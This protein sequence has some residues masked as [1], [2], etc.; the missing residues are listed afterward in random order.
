MTLP[1]S[2]LDVRK[3]GPWAIAPSCAGLAVVAALCSGAVGIAGPVHAETLSAQSRIEGV[4]VFPRGAEVVRVAKIRIPAGQHVVA[5]RDLPAQ[6]VG[7]SI[8]V[9]GKATGALQI[10][11]VD[12]RRTFITRA[13]EEQASLRRRIEADIERLKDER[14]LLEAAVETAETQAELIRNLVQLP[15]APAGGQAPSS[16]VAPRADWGEIY[17]LIGSRLNEARQKALESRVKLRDLDRRIEDLSKQLTAAAPKKTERTEVMV[18]VAAAGPLDAEL[19]VRYQVTDASWQPRYDARLETGARNVAPK[20]TLVRRAAIRQRTGESWEEV[21]LQL[22]T[23]RPA[24][25]TTTPVLNPVT[26]DIQLDLPRPAPVASAPPQVGAVRT[27][28]AP[29]AEAAKVADAEPQ[30]AAQEAAAVVN[31][32]DYA[33]TFAVKERVTLLETG[34][35][36]SVLVDEHSLE[37]TLV[38][39]AVPRLDPKAYLYARVVLPKTAPYLPGPIA[40]FR[41]RAYAGQGNLPQLAPGETHELGFGADD[42]VRVRHSIGEERRGEAGIISSTRTDERTFRIV[43]KNLHERSIAFSILDQVPVSLNQEIKVDLIGKTPPTRRD[44]DDKRG[45]LGW[46]DKLNADEERTI[47][48]GYRMSWPAN[49]AIVYGR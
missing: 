5:L 35:S 49:R 34:D 2:S 25:G 1:P 33:A 40:L 47:E 3:N 31:A 29:M 21:A 26:V 8:R 17:G 48:F 27:R 9:E 14:G 20:L 41:D 45:V 38:V 32:G 15:L 42:L 43:V 22:S 24:A 12:H 46:E 37:P 30:V 44:V 19:A 7:A 36:K 13:E 23:A 10:G 11:A 16:A 39:R 4:T 6:A 18:H 28:S